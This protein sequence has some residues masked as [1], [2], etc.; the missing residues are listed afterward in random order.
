VAR[1]VGG[2]RRGVVLLGEVHTWVF[3]QCGA[4][5]WRLARLDVV[6]AL[7]GC[8]V[9]YFDAAAL[10]LG[11]VHVQ[12][13]TNR[14]E[15]ALVK[16]F[17]P[18]WVLSLLS[19]SRPLLLIPCKSSNHRL[20]EFFCLGIHRTSDHL[21]EVII[22]LLQIVYNLIQP[23]ILFEDLRLAQLLFLDANQVLL[24]LVL[25]LAED[26]LELFVFELGIL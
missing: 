10:D 5:D 16:I 25:L 24:N 9:G 11:K 22:P 17:T 21:A 20:F 14:V 19:G 8:L 12:L 15:S 23:L 13:G 26:S 2:V 3:F 7:W 4:A 18:W 1:L 6:L